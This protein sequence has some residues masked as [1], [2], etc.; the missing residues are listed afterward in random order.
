[1]FIHTLLPTLED[2]LNLTS[3]CVV[4]VFRFVTD[5]TWHINQCIIS[6]FVEYWSNLIHSL[7]IKIGK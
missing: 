1:M 2:D 7:K 5:A 6:L 3:N 4:I